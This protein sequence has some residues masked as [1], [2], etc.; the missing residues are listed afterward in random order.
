MTNTPLPTETPTPLPPTATVFYEPAADAQGRV[1]DDFQ[2]MMTAMVARIRAVD[3][4]INVSQHTVMYDGDRPDGYFTGFKIEAED[5]ANEDEQLVTE[6]RQAIR[7]VLFEFYGSYPYLGVALTVNDGDE[8]IWTWGSDDEIWFAQNPS[9]GDTVFH[10]EPTVVPTAKATQSLD[11][12]AS[13]IIRNTVGTELRD[14]DVEMVIANDRVVTLRYHLRE[15][16]LPFFYKLQA[17]TDF[18]LLVCN[19]R[20]NGFTTQTFQF[21]A[22]APVTDS[23]GNK[24]YVEAVEMILAPE[25][26]A[27]IN[28]DNPKGVVLEDIAERYTVN[29]PY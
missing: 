4:V 8:L 19:L 18:V 29:L 5:G 27:R 23:F 7:N 20:K 28:C 15:T 3:G 1:P 12:I 24:V 17:D 13:S 14:S 22:D 16:G 21:S 6:I 9:T 11:E 25:T 26:A 10:I 2:A